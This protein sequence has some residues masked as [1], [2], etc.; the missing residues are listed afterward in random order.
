MQNQITH[1]FTLV[2]KTN[3]IGPFGVVGDIVVVSGAENLA[4][5]KIAARSLIKTGRFVASFEGVNSALL[6]RTY[7]HAH[8]IN[9]GSQRIAA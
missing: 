4:S 6:A 1:L 5:A 2:I 7:R 3:Q 9:A 8:C